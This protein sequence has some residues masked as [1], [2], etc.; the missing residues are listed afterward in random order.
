MPTYH[1]R[2]PLARAN[3]LRSLPLI[4]PAGATFRMSDQDR[5]VWPLQIA[6]RD[7][8]LL[9][10]RYAVYCAAL[11]AANR[12]RGPMKRHWQAQ[13]FRQINAARAQLRAARKALVV[14]EAAMLQ[15]AVA[16]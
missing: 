13:A 9:E 2:N 16:A 5:A 15:F 4:R 11:G 6:R 7:V 3:P 14:A 8:P 1:S 12:M 10:K